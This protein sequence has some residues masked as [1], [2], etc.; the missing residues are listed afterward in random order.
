MPNPLHDRRYA[1]FRSLLVEA[2]HAAGLT[3]VEVAVRLGRP[4]SFISKMERGE[5]RLDFP[6]FVALADAIGIDVT[7]FLARYR[8]AVG[9]GR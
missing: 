1:L 4:Q 6:E 7:D 9:K 3:Q 5:R 8:D 2:R